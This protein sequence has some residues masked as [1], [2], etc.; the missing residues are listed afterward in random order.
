VVCARAGKFRLVP[1][2]LMMYVLKEV[3]GQP[4]PISPK[5]AIVKTILG[6][7]SAFRVPDA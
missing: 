1:V 5:I 3:F 7:R 4:Q 6:R 2:M